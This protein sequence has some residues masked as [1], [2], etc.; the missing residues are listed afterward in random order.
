MSMKSIVHK[1][2]Q[3]SDG[4]IARTVDVKD[5][6]SVLVS[7]EDA[8]TRYTI[9]RHIIDWFDLHEFLLKPAM[10]GLER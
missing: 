5:D 8:H 6:D 4:S 7:N 9:P 1:S 10:L 2:I 3:A